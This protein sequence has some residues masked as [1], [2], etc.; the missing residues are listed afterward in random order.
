MASRPGRV[1]VEG[2]VEAAPPRL[3]EFSAAASGAI[4]QNIDPVSFA[5]ETGLPLLPLVIVEDATPANAGDGLERNWSPPATDVQM[6]YGYAF[7]WFAIGAGIV[8][9]YVRF[10]IVRPRERRRA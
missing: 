3:F 9:L 7:Q 8:F 4:R 6:H 5:R 2:S 1:T 10:R